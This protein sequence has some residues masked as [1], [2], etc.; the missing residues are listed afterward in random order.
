MKKNIV[1]DVIPGKRTIRNVEL[2]TRGRSSVSD[3]KREVVRESARPKK[4]PPSEDEFARPVKLKQEATAQKEPIEPINV[5]EKVTQSKPPKPPFTPPSTTYKYEYEEPKRGGKKFLLISVLVLLVVAG[6]GISSFFESATI[7]FTPEKQ[8]KSLDDVFT[9][10]KEVSANALSFQTVTLPKEVEKTIDSSITTV[11]KQVDV[12]AKG[13]IVIYNMTSQVQKL[14]ATTRFETPE[15]LVYRITGPVSVPAKQVVNGKNVAGSIEAIVEA[16]KPGDKYN[17]AMKDFTVPGFKGDPKYTQ[18]YGRSKT[19]MT[20]GF[21]GIQKVISGDASLQAEKQM[22]AELKD[23]LSKA[24]ITQ[25]PSEFILYPDSLTYKFEPAQ[26]TTSSNGAT[27]MKK[28]GIATGLIFNRALLAKTL[29]GKLLPDTSGDA[30]KVSNL[31]DLSFAISSSTSFDATTSQSINFSLKGQPIFVWTLDENRLKSDLLGL[32]KTQAKA[33]IAKYPMIKEAWIETHPFW[34]QS[35]P[36]DSE[37]V[38]V[39]NTLTK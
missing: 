12:K 33:V 38:T 8:T 3:E 20:G 26:V 2:P 34:K 19:E 36:L 17:I 21:S 27:I 22:E 23:S 28:K 13:K 1:Q 35:I 30:I 9:A 29:A 11:D 32:S 25:I 39:V 10:K 18:I 24:I 16:D 15:G 5:I 31:E 7:K 4:Q 6:F 14:I 37:K